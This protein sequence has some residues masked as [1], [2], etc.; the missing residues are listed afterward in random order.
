MTTD[1]SPKLLAGLAAGVVVIV[2]LIGW[3]ALVSPQRSKADSL[4]RQIADARTA[5]TAAEAPPPPV[6]K[7]KQTSAD[8]LATA[9]PAT[10]G[11]PALLRQVQTLAATSNSAFKPTRRAVAASRPP[12]ACSRSRAS[13]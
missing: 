13:A 10:L 8:A 1:M 3:F 2:A 11:M 4:D 9:L 7:P 6:K 5:L 12:A